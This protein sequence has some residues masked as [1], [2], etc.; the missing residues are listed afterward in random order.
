MTFTIDPFLAGF[1][2]GWFCGVMFIT[3]VALLA[4]RGN[5]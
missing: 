1:C 3:G 5:R 2:V 4:T